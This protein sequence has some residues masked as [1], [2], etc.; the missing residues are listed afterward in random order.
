MRRK[1]DGRDIKLHRNSKMKTLW[2]KLVSRHKRF[3]AEMVQVELEMA[4]NPPPPLI[5]I[6]TIFPRKPY[7][8]STLILFSVFTV[9]AAIAV[10]IS[11]RELI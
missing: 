7:R 2:H 1:T 11:F 8:I 5:P 6:P 4:K 3:K 10:W 9:F